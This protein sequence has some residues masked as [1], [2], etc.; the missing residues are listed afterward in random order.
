M[1]VWKVK[2]NGVPFSIKG[3]DT[4]PSEEQVMEAY[5]SYNRKIGLPSVEEAGVPDTKAP[6]LGKAADI[7][8]T[9]AMG[10]LSWVP[11]YRTAFVNEMDAAR[12]FWDS[13][14]AA[15]PRKERIQRANEY[16][17]E[18][19]GAE[20]NPTASFLGNLTGGMALASLVGPAAFART[21]SMINTMLG[22]VPQGAGLLR[23][24][25]TG[26]VSGGTYGVA[27]TF[28][29]ASARDSL[30]EAQ[31]V[32]LNA[33]LGST[34]GAG[35]PLAVAGSTAA[36]RKIASLPVVASTLPKLGNLL[37]DTAA[38][39]RGATA[40]KKAAAEKKVFLEGDLENAMQRYG[41]QNESIAETPNSLVQSAAKVLS[42]TNPREAN[43]LNRTVISPALDKQERL[44]QS[45]F[46]MIGDNIG[47]PADSLNRDAVLNAKWGAFRQQLNGAKLNQ[48]ISM[49]DI[50]KI[51]GSDEI[52]NEI[53]NGLKDVVDRDPA[54]R[55]NYVRAGNRIPPAAVD[56][57]IREIAGNVNA[58]NKAASEIYLDGLYGLL[59][60]KKFNNIR[61]YKADW[62]KL[63]NANKAFSEGVEAA[64]YNDPEAISLAMNKPVRRFKLA[65]GQKG[66]RGEGKNI[67]DTD[68]TEEAMKARRSGFVN[69]ARNALNEGREVNV[70]TKAQRD[71]LENNGYSDFLKSIEKL[72]HLQRMQV[73]LRSTGDIAGGMEGAITAL[74]NLAYPSGPVSAINSGPFKRALGRL[75]VESK[76]KD[77]ADFM[78]SPA[79]SAKTYLNPGR[80]VLDRNITGAIAN[81]VGRMLR[82]TPKEEGE[83]NERY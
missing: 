60:Q 31:D 16:Y 53:W 82:T 35:V 47:T 7:F 73:L 61:E 74:T 37:K 38:K 4:P 75:N 3:G 42:E 34:T 55:L 39:F 11:G 8:N 2:I 21:P 79:S 70:F 46:K 26:A 17:D 67:I 22:R 66:L 29:D 64:K 1:A 24:I 57:Y 5:E 36:G 71:W 19:E 69:E 51:S 27:K 54:L 40:F 33:A 62:N 49:D 41:T 30:P 78:M 83:T 25:A 77:L 20:R 15:L 72:N 45:N 9:W 58:S 13:N 43:T 14:Y 48:H 28:A 18:Y 81:T 23:R 68:L 56:K 59:E 10:N 44:V 76:A 12:A 52:A 65:A 80:S 6:G 63:F 50:T 32:M